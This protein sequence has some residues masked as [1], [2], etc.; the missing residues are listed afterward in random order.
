MRFDG[1]A[2]GS[3]NQET[4]L[5]LC[6]RAGSLLRSLDVSDASCCSLSVEDVTHVLA[7]DGLGLGLENLRTRASYAWW[8]GW[9][10]DEVFPA[11]LRTA[12]PALTP[13]VTVRGSPAD[14]E[15]ALR[16]LPGPG[17]KWTRVTLGS[18]EHRVAASILVSL[19]ALAD[20]LPAALAAYSIDDLMLSN[21][22]ADLA[23]DSAQ[24]EAAV[25]RLAKALVAPVSGVRRL[26]IRE[27][28]C[29]LAG[30]TPLLASL[31]RA[32]TA[33]SP[34]TELRVYDSALTGALAL[35]ISTALAP[36]RSRLQTLFLGGHQ[37]DL[38]GGGGCA[39]VF[40]ATS[41]VPIPLLPLAAAV[42]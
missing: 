6:Q 30:A 32:L 21:F 25:Q 31:C 24:H 42:V 19:S 2:P 11:A 26:T 23:E 13:A 17:R 34:L 3:V 38:S 39:S 10:R 1:A 8:D 9:L 41:C 5:R 22:T 27:Y 29:T 14:V 12:C 15:A 33:E 7:S 35:E 18:T 4:L 37:A 40:P 20:W 28:R 16:A 36:G